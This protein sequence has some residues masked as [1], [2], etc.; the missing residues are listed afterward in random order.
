MSYVTQ[1]PPGEVANGQSLSPPA[2]V[3]R[4]FAIKSAISLN[5]EPLE[6]SLN[7]KL[8]AAI[9]TLAEAITLA[10]DIGETK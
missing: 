4:Y 3:T 5:G 10:R 7:H 8:V 9:L 6:Q 1:P 2:I